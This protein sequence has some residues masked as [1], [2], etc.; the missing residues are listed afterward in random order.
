[1]KNSLNRKEQKLLFNVSS[2]WQG[3][4]QVKKG[5]KFHLFLD[6]H[7]GGQKVPRRAV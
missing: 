4:Q 5:K 2:I 6:K 3:F 1:M 7:F